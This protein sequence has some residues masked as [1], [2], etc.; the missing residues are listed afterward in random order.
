MI[1]YLKFCFLTCSLL[2]YRNT[3]GFFVLGDLSCDFAELAYQFQGILQIS[4]DFLRRSQCHLQK[5]KSFVFFHFQSIWLL[6]LFLPY[7]ANQNVQDYVES[8][9]S[10]W[11]SLPAKKKKKQKKNSQGKSISSFIKYDVSYRFLVDILY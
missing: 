5:K 10:K 9:W 1:F 3:V 7:C 8:Q 2:V 4:W 6:F 11:I